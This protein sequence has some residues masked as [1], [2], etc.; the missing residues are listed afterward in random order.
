MRFC[1]VSC[2]RVNSSGTK[3]GIHRMKQ[4]RRRQ[5]NPLHHFP[6][7][8]MRKTVEKGQANEA[9]NDIHQKMKPDMHRVPWRNLSSCVFVQ[10]HHHLGCGLQNNTHNLSLPAHS[11]GIFCLLCHHRHSCF[12]RFPIRAELHSD[13]CF[14]HCCLQSFPLFLNVDLK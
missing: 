3:Q 1:F 9:T 11:K 12:H 14:L 5:R 8:Y 6:S 4:N 13:S 10:T 7:R 2:V